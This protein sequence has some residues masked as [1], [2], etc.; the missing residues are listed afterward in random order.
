MSTPNFRQPNLSKI[1]F[2]KFEEDWQYDDFIDE[3]E[4]EL[5]K[6]KEYSSN[7]NYGKWLGDKKVIGTIEV[8]YYDHNYNQWT[9]GYIYITIEDGYY[10]GCMIDVDL[11]DFKGVDI[12]KTVQKKIDRYCLR[13]EKILAKITTPIVRVATF[14]NG[15]AIYKLA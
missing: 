8:Y 7:K 14:S 10:Q 15:E 11:D 9:T 5:K 1:Y 6:I 12:G 4:E 3:L 2:Q 13:V